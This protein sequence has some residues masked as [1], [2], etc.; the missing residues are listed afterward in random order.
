MKKYKKPAIL[1]SVLVVGVITI[2]IL[3]GQGDQGSEYSLKP[4]DTIKDIHGLAVDMADQNKLYIATHHGLLLLKEDGLFRVGKSETDFM[5]FSLHPKDPKTFYSSGH[6][7][8][9]GNIGFQRSADGGI[10][11]EKISNGANGPVDF[12]SIAISPVNPNLMYGWHQTSLQRSIDG[13]HTW[14]LVD[15]NVPH[16]IALYVDTADEN[17]LYAIT[18]AGV[19]MSKD[20][21][22]TWE[23]AFPEYSE[24]LTTALTVDP[25]DP[26]SILLF[27]R[28]QG[29]L[30][31]TDGGENW[32]EIGEDFGG[33]IV[34]YFAQS[35]KD[36][37][38]IYAATHKYAIY[39]SDD[40][41]EN[42]SK[43][44]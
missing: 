28:K 4:V 2:A 41:G 24:S 44:R 18:I 33:E 23:R 27:A 13:G 29:L 39:R 10:S 25:K 36:P 43:I 5:G 40:K 19:F 32:N 9:G 21:G 16:S 7:K 30:S 20:R 1:L 22:E 42:W 38:R 3:A 34:I 15:T 17:S 14:E 12:H 37:N 11:W 31:T 6:P 26:K 35:S 8:Y